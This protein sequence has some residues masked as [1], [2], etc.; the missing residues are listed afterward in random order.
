MTD[1]IKALVMRAMSEC[2]EN[3]KEA[4]VLLVKWAR[5]DSELMTEILTLG[6]D[7]AIRSFFQSERKAAALYIP[8]VDLP[9][10]EE[11]RAR[12]AVKVER[13]LFWD[14]Y[15]LFGQTPLKGARVPDL[16][17]SFNKRRV[18]AQGN[19]NCAAFEED[20]AKR[21]GVKS[22]STVGGFFHVDKVIELAK[23]HNVVN[24]I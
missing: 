23:A 16:R 7:Q 9:P 24:S 15:A 10:T 21:M 2:D 12:R 19:L 4:K 6:A 22:K 11:T 18:M 1:S 14:R 20:L 5:K 17:D 3:P 8:T 13:R